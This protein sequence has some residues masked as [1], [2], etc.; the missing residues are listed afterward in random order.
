MRL[1]VQSAAHPLNKRCSCLALSEGVA[2]L[3]PVGMPPYWH[4]WYWLKAGLVLRQMEAMSGTMR[5]GG[6]FSLRS[7]NAELYQFH[8]FAAWRVQGH[9][10][11][12]HIHD[13]VILLTCRRAVMT[14]ESFRKK[15]KISP[16][17]TQFPF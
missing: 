10:S 2:R 12:R 6:S 13:C 16:S 4:R 15:Q 8:F 14:A 9:S 5:S 17:D 7:V 1:C 3:Q 11:R